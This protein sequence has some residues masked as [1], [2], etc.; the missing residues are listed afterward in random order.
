MRMTGRRGT[1]AARVQ[2]FAFRVIQTPTAAEKP[3]RKVPQGRSTRTIR[4]DQAV[5]VAILV[6]S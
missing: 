4:Q 2:I 3:V 1:C 6:N 5:S